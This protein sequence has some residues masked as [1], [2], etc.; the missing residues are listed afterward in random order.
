MLTGVMKDI[1]LTIAEEN[2]K[3]SYSVYTSLAAGAEV[4]IDS[5]TVS[6]SVGKLKRILVSSAVP[7]KA[8]VKTVINGVPTTKA[9]FFVFPERH[10][11]FVPEK[12]ITVGTN[13][14]FRVTVKNMEDLNASDVYVTFIWQEV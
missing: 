9:T 5:S 7:L 4:D 6:G 10:G 13:G 14:V 11:E 1:S 8:T 2:L 3:V 12:A